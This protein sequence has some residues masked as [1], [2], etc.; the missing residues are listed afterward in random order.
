MVMRVWSR[1]RCCALFVLTGMLSACARVPVSGQ[2]N[3]KLW[4]GRLVVKIQTKPVQSWIVSFDLEGDFDRGELLLS[5]PL[6][7]TIAQAKWDEKR[8]ELIQPNHPT[9]YFLNLN[10]LWKHLTKIEFDLEVLFFWLAEKPFAVPT[11]WQADSTK[12][13]LRLLRYAQGNEPEIHLDV[14]I[15]LVNDEVK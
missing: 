12:E 10:E 9:Q 1:R 3:I 13:R 6:G 8:A 11:G 14:A 15:T 2:S 5:G 7:Q 4:S